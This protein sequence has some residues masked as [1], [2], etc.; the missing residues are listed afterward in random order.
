M[1]HKDAYEELEDYLHYED[2][3]VEGDM[4]EAY[5]GGSSSFCIDNRRWGDNGMSGLVIKK[6]ARFI[7]E[8][9]IF[10]SMFIE[11]G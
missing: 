1:V 9:P 11:G 3:D 2:E 7:A 4:D 5:Y 8:L 10:R 6:L